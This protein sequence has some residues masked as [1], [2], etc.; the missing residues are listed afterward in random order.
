MA[1]RD[2]RRFPP[3]H[4]VDALRTLLSVSGGLSD[5]DRRILDT[6]ASLA[7]GLPLPDL[8]RRIVAA[9]CSLVD[10]RYGALGVIGH[11]RLLVEFI[12]EGMDDDSVARIGHLPEGH[13]VLGALID[14]PRPIRIAN[15][16]DHT[17]SFGFPGHHPPM[18]SFLGAPI[19][20]GEEVFGNI[21]LTEKRGA[22]DFSDA[23]EDLIV[24]L[25]A[26]AGLAIANARRVSETERREQALGALQGVAT[27]LLAGTA[28]HDVLMLMA[29]HAREILGGELATIALPDA[30]RETLTVKVAVGER[31]D[32]VLGQTVSVAESISG[33]ALESGEPVNLAYAPTE[34]RVFQPL[35]RVAGIG[36]L[37]VV[38]L[39][40][41][42]ETYATLAVARNKGRPPFGD[43][44]L[45]L[46]QS[47]ATQASVALEY[48]AAQRLVQKIAVYEDQERIA[49]DLH[50]S[51][52]QQ[53]FAV[54]MR[55]QGSVPL[56]EDESLAS[57]IQDAVD[58]IDD[59]IR[60]IRSTIFSLSRPSTG[61]R[62]GAQAALDEFS[63]AYR[64]E[65][66]L[67]IGGPVDS[68]AS[69]E[70]CAE[71]LASLREALSNVGRHAR[72]QRVDVSLSVDDR[73]LVLRVADDGVGL[74]GRVPHGNGLRNMAERAERLGGAFSATAR[75]DGTGTAI[76][77]RVP[78]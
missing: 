25:A 3:E 24:A 61:M 10:A 22:A 68:A 45:R 8:L 11:D 72:A 15:V 6:F 62:T 40:L 33:Q 9:A 5:R 21:Y 57:R 2:G 64:V 41:G 29:S 43:D 58:T 53:L 66:G 56:I 47:F 70:L 49:R 18:R 12:H 14:D 65:F 17:S 13:G 46:L 26:A 27:A 44:D 28:E 51:V 69:D 37:V 78:V 42:G 75:P 63:R 23:D 39:W 59:A 19:R 1:D 77:W 35:A 71:A 54:G 38:P 60:S 48:G 34:Q 73:Q 50:D 16:A 20:V 76:E 52:I 32:E 4:S 67:E 55:L 30:Q 31:R 74:P 7:E 36:P